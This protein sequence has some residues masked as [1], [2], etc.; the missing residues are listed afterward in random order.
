MEPSSF[1]M[2]KSLCHLTWEETIHISILYFS[3]IIPVLVKLNSSR[4]SVGTSQNMKK[5]IPILGEE[6][7]FRLINITLSIVT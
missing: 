4:H 3:A 6:P 2:S 5:N 1:V 7:S